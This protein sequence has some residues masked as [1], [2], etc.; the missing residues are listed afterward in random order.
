MANKTKNDLLME[1]EELKKKLY[2]TEDKLIKY[3]QISACVDMGA[4]YKLIYDKYIESGFTE[5]QA[6]E[7]LKIVTD[8]TV[9]QFLNDIKYGKHRVSYHRY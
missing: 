2:E 9:T 4:E 3:E 6:F 8:R 7:L 5:E 1:V